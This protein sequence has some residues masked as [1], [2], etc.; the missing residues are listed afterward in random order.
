MGDGERSAASGRF[1]GV[2]ELTA[3]TAAAICGRVAAGES[4]MAVGRDPEMPHRTTIRRWAD[5]DPDF[6]LRLWEAMREARLE[7][8]RLDREAAAAR[9]ARPAPVKGGKPSSYTPA[10][11]EAI[12]ARLAN[13]ESLVAIVRDPE[14]PCYGTVYGWLKRHP[15][16][17]DL[18][19]QARQ[20]Q[21]DYFF[22]EAREVAQGSTHA[23]VWSDRLRFDTIRWQAAR[24][25]PR[26]YC[27]RVIVEAEIA[28]RRAEVGRQDSKL[29]L[30]LVDFQQGPNGKVLVA[31]PRSE[32]EEQAW[33]EAYGHPYDGPR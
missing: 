15:V 11:G 1:V 7:R 33:V 29:T 31:P 18:Y 20:I 30:R 13:G 28:T 22:D 21:A 19:V 12:C 25:A 3:A 14:M 2:C 24:I 16:F 8:R 26:K 32:N 17:A 9:A 6:R 4:L 10:V 23:T 27:E 5:R